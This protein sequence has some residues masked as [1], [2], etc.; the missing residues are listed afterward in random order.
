[1]Y[2]V[3]TG[4]LGGVS[5]GQQLAFKIDK[6]RKAKTVKNLILRELAS[7]ESPDAD[8]AVEEVL[9]FVRT[10]ASFHFPRYLM[11]LDRIQREVFLPWIGGAGDYSAYAASVENMFTSTGLV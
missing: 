4:R 10:W 6:F 3:S 1:K 11:A 9:D 8:A 7:Q 5:S 2:F